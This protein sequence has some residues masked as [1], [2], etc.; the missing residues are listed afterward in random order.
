M[1]LAWASLV[2]GDLGCSHPVHLACSYPKAWPFFATTIRLDLTCF[3]TFQANLV[4]VSAGPELLQPASACCA[5]PSLG[6][7]SLHRWYGSLGRAPCPPLTPTEAGFF[8][9]NRPVK[10]KPGAT[11]TSKKCLAISEQWPRPPPG[12]ATIPPKAET[13]H[14]GPYVGLFR[15]MP[16]N[17]AARVGVLNDTHAGASNS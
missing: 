1:S 17:G 3:T 7:G 13:D 9:Q 15:G 4:P 5:H 11:I 16:D 14:E 10:V 6:P 12:C 2:E 8:A